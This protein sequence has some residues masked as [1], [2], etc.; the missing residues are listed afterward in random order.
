L[1][2]EVDIVEE[3]YR[4]G[5]GAIKQAMDQL[6]ELVYWEKRGAQLMNEPEIT[7]LKARIASLFEHRQPLLELARH[8]IPGDLATLRRRR[9]Y[10]WAIAFFLATAGVFLAHLTL[11]PFALGW[12]VWPLSAA[13]AIVVAWWV[14]RTLEKF[15]NPAVVRV[16]C[17]VALSVSLAGVFLMALLRGDILL[18]YLKGLMDAE[19]PGTADSFYQSAI[20]KLRILMG[21]LALAME[22]GVGM[23]AHEARKLA[24]A[25]CCRQDAERARKEALT[26]DDHLG[27]LAHRHVYLENEPGIIEAHAKR[28]FLL[29]VFDGLKRNG[30]VHLMLIVSL[31]LSL[32]P[33]LLLGG[34]RTCDVIGLDLSLSEATTGY[35]GTTDYEKNMDAVA[36]FI[37]LLPVD[38]SFTIMAITDESFQRPYTLLSGQIPASSGPLQFYDQVA[39]KKRQIA[40]EVRRL[41]RSLKPTYQMTDVLG[42]VIAAG[43]VLRH[44]PAESKRL[45]LFSDMRHYTQEIDIEHPIK[46]V[47]PQTLARVQQYNL[48]ADLRGIDVYVLGVDGA[49][50]SACYW[51]SLREFWVNYF[52]KAGADLK[53]FSMS[54]DLQP[55]T[56]H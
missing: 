28:N 40:A 34:D 33:T 7:Q 19:T 35:D 12:E 11:A 56:R 21:L 4:L 22:L 8:S 15:D 26:L 9:W 6:A 43:D 10:Y 45:V 53:T 52:K 24:L 17:V 42:A 16:T 47:V 36:R 5:E 44:S 3:A 29:G 27:A 13:V 49:N 41:G 18:M 51:E 55:L 23:A 38:S 30:L 39:A 46:I 32:Q 48:L 20:P 50:K 1:K 25:I 2:P 31:L 14:D 37:S 54:R